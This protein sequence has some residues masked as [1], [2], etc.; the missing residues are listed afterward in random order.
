MALNF[1]GKYEFPNKQFFW[2]NNDLVFTELP[3]LFLEYKNEV[4][5]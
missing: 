3:E 4:E 1:K 5:N 2:A